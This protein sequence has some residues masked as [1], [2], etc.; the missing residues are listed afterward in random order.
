MGAG[1]RGLATG[2]EWNT[3]TASSG[4]ANSTICHWDI[5]RETL[6]SSFQSYALRINWDYAE[7]NRFAETTGGY[8]GATEWI[9][10]V[11]EHAAKACEAAGRAAIVLGSAA[12]EAGGLFDVVMADPPYY[13]AIPYSDL[14]DYFYV[15]LRRTI[16][17]EHLDAFSH[18]L[19]RISRQD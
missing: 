8:P 4:V 12:N 6:S 2:A 9:S 19:I 17:S 10:L 3:R 1:M 13:D 16:G 14:S 5:G 11:I 18:P 7:V 15:W